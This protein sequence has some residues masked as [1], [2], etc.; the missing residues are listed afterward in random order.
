MIEVSVKALTTEEQI[1]LVEL[2]VF[3]EDA[4]VPEAAI[5]TL[6]EST[7]RVSSR[8]GRKL[9]AK[10]KQ[11]SLIQ[12]VADNGS[13]DAHSGHGQFSL[14]N[15]IHDYGVARYLK[16]NGDVK[17]LHTQLLDAYRAKAPHRWWSGPNDGY[18]FQQLRHHLIAADRN[19]DALALLM[20][21]DWLRA[22]THAGLTMDLSQEMFEAGQSTDL[23]SLDGLG[24]WYYFLRSNPQFLHQ[25]PQCFFQQA[26]N[27][28]IDSPVSRAA[29]R[30]WAAVRQVG[31][32]VPHVPSAI[33][34]WTNRHRDWEPP[35]CLMTLTGHTWYVRSVA[36][37]VDGMTI[38]S[39]SADKT[40]KVWD[41]RTGT[42]LHTLTGHAGEVTSVACFADGMTVV[43]GAEDKAVKVWDAQSGACRLT[44]TGH[45]GYVL[46]VACSTDGRILVSGSEDNTVNVWLGH[47]GDCLRTLTGHRNHVNSVACTAD[48]RVI[49]SGSDDGDVRVW[50][51]QTGQCL[52]TLSEHEDRVYTVACSADGRTIISGSQDKTVKV[53]DAQ[54]GTCLRTFTGHKENVT[55]VACSADGRTI[56]SGANDVKFWDIQSGE[57]LRTFRGFGGGFAFSADQRMFVSGGSG[58]TLKAWDI[59]AGE[60]RPRLIGHEKNVTQLDCSADRRI[61][62]TGS[63]DGTV[64][65]WDART[66]NCLRTLPRHNRTG[67]DHTIRSVACSADGRTVVSLSGN[68]V[69]FW[70]VETGE[71][72]LT[73]T[74]TDCSPDD[75]AFSADELLLYSWPRDTV[76]DNFDNLLKV[77]DAETG[78]CLA[79]HP[80]SSK[81]AQA[82]CSAVQRSTQQKRSGLCAEIVSGNLVV[83]TI[84]NVVGRATSSSSSGDQESLPADIGANDQS[85]DS[86]ENDLSPIRA[87]GSS[88]SPAQR[89]IAPGPF[90]EALGP[91]FEDRIVAFTDSG[92][93]HWFRIRRRDEATPATRPVG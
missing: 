60:S 71:C 17:L 38:I 31:V 43:S 10:L 27:E 50:D 65:I 58:N 87:S 47:T 55:C 12:L 90:W 26:F 36:L 40:V 70:D 37:S 89:L 39:G 92:E 7:G 72:R 68:M 21:F 1:R 93:A 35:A 48:G 83:E 80:M 33:L 29:Q 56:I 91:L 6:W 53:W 49:V 9:L 86:H 11:R 52:Q 16:S 30:A 8:N 64:R 79:T 75:V 34:E 18:F 20:D 76:L 5:T 69:K 23:H 73:S 3:P 46:G 88:I 28:P 32:H 78:A 45:L 54:S 41:A 63:Y 84:V 77:W 61:V 2:V 15:L 4:A 62:V 66:G 25:H 42:C 22:K 51:S 81:E 44:L 19:D 14:H 82:V 59:Q 67:W 74:I 13:K 57:C 85:G 24:P